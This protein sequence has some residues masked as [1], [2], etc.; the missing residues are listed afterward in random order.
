MSGFAFVVIYISA[1][2]VAAAIWMRFRL[3]RQPVRDRSASVA[4]IPGSGHAFFWR[5][6]SP[7]RAS[8]FISGALRLL[9]VGV[10]LAAPW[11]LLLVVDNGILGKPLPDYLEMLD[12]V[13]AAGLIA[14]GSI[15]PVVL[16]ALGSGF[17][18][19]ATYI[20]RW[21]QRNIG[22]DIRSA[23]ST[24][25]QD[26]S[27]SFYERYRTGDVL[28]KL[29]TAV[30]QVEDMVVA[31]FERALPETL[32]VVG[33]LA[34]MTLVDPSFALAALI[35]AGALVWWVRRAHRSVHSA[36]HTVRSASRTM[37]DDAGDTL[38]N[39]RPRQVFFRQDLGAEAFDARSRGT[40][41]TRPAVLERSARMA[42]MPKI[43]LG[44]ATAAVLYLGAIQVLDGT[45]SMGVLLVLLAYTAQLYA[46]TADLA[47]SVLTVA[48]GAASCDLLADLLASEPGVSESA[49]AIDAPAGP[50]PLR[51]H[52]LAF[53][54]DN[55]WPVLR[56][57]NF[58][59]A[60]GEVV[61]VVGSN[62]A[63]K[64]TLLSL[65]LRLHDPATG[66][67]ELG[68]IDIR[69]LKLA[70]MRSRIAFVPQDLWVIDGTIAANIAFGR[71]GATAE[72]VAAAAKL[73]MADEFI[74]AFPAGYNTVV[75][76]R[77]AELTGG[78]R[79]KLALARALIREAPIL[80]LDEP[81][82]G[83]DAVS[84]GQVRRAVTSVCAE[85]GVLIV[86]DDLEVAQRA[87]RIFVVEKGA[88]VESGDH[89]ALLQH[90][91][92]Y[93]ALWAPAGQ[94]STDALAMEQ[95]TVSSLATALT[96]GSPVAATERQLRDVLADVMGLDPVSV[97]GHFFDELGADSMVMARFCARVRKQT[98][99]PAVAMKQVYEHPTLNSLATAL[100][101]VTPTSDLSAAQVVTTPAPA[102]AMRRVGPLSY[103]LCGAL[104]LLT[105]FGYLSLI[106][107][108]LAGGAAWIANGSSLV[109]NLIRAAAVGNGI[110]VGT[111]ILPI[112]VKWVLIGRWKP[113]EIRIW[114]LTYFRFWVVKTLVTLNPL[115]LFAG[116]PIY[117]LYLRA[118]GAKIGRN[119]V[120][121]SRRVP[122]C[123]D[124]L[125]VGDNTVIRK[126][127]FFNCY[128]AHGGLIKTGTVTLGRD[129]Y[130]GESTVLDIDTSMGDG[131]QLAHSSSLV[132]GQSV[133]AGEHRCGSPARERTEVN[134]QNVA[135]T[136]FRPLRKIAF[137]SVQL[138]NWLMVSS[139]VFSL[140]FVVGSALA[141]RSYFAGGPGTSALSQRNLYVDAFFVAGL[142]LFGA[143]LVRLI[144]VVTI[145]RVLNL[146]IEP[147]RAYPLYG[148]HYLAHRAI[149]RLTNVTFFTHLFGDSSYIVSY[150]RWLGYDLSEGVVQTGSNFGSAV[151]HDNPYMVSIG[152]GTMIADG[153]SI[154]NADYS[155]TSFR[156][157]RVTIGADNFLGNQ[158]AYPSQGKTGDNCL[159]ATKVMV[160]VDG[161]V[162]EGVGLLGAPSF[163]I[164]RSV[165]RDSG[166][167]HPKTNEELD[168]RLA[169]KNRHNLGT[170][171]L[172]LLG[173][174]FFFFGSVLLAFGAV[175]LSQ[176]A[177]AFV[178]AL[179]G[180][181]TLLFRVL[182]QIL[183]ERA[184]TFFHPLRPRQCSIYEPYFW[185]H[186]RY[187]K[188]AVRPIHLALFAGTPL[189][190]LFWR[191]M[192]VRIGRRVFDDGGVVTERTL[193]AIGD[194]CT[195]NV[196][197]VIQ[198]HSQEDGGFKCDRIEIGAECTIGTSALVH[199]GVTMG[200]GA[201]LAPGAFLMKGEEVPPHAQWEDNPAREV[202][203]DDFARGAITTAEQV[204]P[205]G[206]GE[207][208]E[209]PVKQLA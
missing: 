25:L 185:Y 181:L 122:V 148:F 155:N 112:L 31:W 182:Y 56:N 131:A 71:P 209:I 127:S 109:D 147:G 204:R 78:Q 132:A 32:T 13:S 141:D 101:G 72:D 76:D 189:K 118:L 58:A 90:D 11:P 16:V 18:Y 28:V 77:G 165:L 43:L 143:I 160:P 51:V 135:P 93:A 74:A 125:T 198:S 154:I 163:E 200:D 167:D 166:L 4:P 192:G 89:E 63:A 64:S 47:T 65:L 81:T 188:L 50:I 120:V 111:A 84:A 175:I 37:L 54:Y 129:V 17:D 178:L 60:P 104:Q 21:A 85:R 80:I 6:A 38:R 103:R 62:E 22:A 133:P 174:W 15:V 119:V 79:R 168:R 158:V 162:R 164:P 130:I 8:L 172:F 134:Y 70:S 46:P 196:G 145:P 27:V 153:L 169:A 33:I 171:G 144:F 202:E 34:V 75:G 20:D 9:V 161:D 207:S 82:A 91:G 14:I 68:G 7:Y 193:V 121:L 49:D 45:I 183:L 59:V 52:D 41:K 105:L 201:Q 100:I 2:V 86:T 24:R 203:S 48:R 35:G 3:D 87:D 102:Q 197:S 187:W 195:L 208:N 29:S 199:Y 92:R 73:A 83:L 179:A 142:L 126:D 19:L 206:D 96:D 30:Y 69:D 44:A 57:I 97:D 1:T 116:S 40:A 94:P 117:V 39:R 138:L 140:A 150:L 66:A 115:A 42:P 156:L 26:T 146:A 149:S 136:H 152:R 107:F 173:E 137:I 194:H 36:E 170:I 99:L 123:T 124:L 205:M 191:L 98:D 88:T 61:C 67:I 106:T 53:G 180:L 113:E 177:G 10:I 190:S 5:F 12:G 114:G 23:V 110:V 176:T 157:S 108:A 184:A 151:K 159:L 55:T 128:H 186:E 139:L 95:P